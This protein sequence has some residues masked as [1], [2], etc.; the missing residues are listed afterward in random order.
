MKRS[1]IKVL[2]I[3]ALAMLAVPAAAQPQQPGPT[4]EWFTGTWS[5]H[6]DCRNPVRFL[7]DG[8]F[9]V[10]A[11]GAEGRWRMDGDAIL[12]SANGREERMPMERLDQNR[13]RAVGNGIISY[14]CEGPNNTRSR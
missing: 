12:L 14:R 6:E 8:R 1:I 5:D 11:N 13:A 2:P 3:A 10:V 4:A 9:V 7:P